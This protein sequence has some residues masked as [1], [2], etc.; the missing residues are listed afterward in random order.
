MKKKSRFWSKRPEFARDRV[1]KASETSFID[2]RFHCGVRT[3][4]EYSSS[5]KT[6]TCY[7]SLL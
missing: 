3:K 2:S 5:K 4:T 6:F 1:V 7:I